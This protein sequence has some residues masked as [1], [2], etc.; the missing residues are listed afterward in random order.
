MTDP[1]ED[2]KLPQLKTEFKVI[3]LD[4]LDDP[5]RPMRSDLSPESVEDLVI[6][7]R[8]VGIIEPLVVKFKGDRYEIIAG[9]RRLLAATIA[10][11]AQVPCYVVEADD[12]LSEILKIHENLFRRE[13]SAIDE[14]KFYDWLIQHYK[15][16]PAKIAGMISKS[17]NYVLDRL[18]ILEYQTELREALAKGQIK[19]SVARAF[20]KVTDLD[21]M[22]KFL[23]YSIRSGIT[24]GLAETWVAEWKRSQLS[25]PPQTAIQPVGDSAG[26]EYITYVD[27]V[28]C[29]EQVKLF[30]ALPVHIH[31]GCYTEI[32]KPN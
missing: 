31:P 21:T 4:M 7:I 29:R 6:S 8:Q 23:Y 20:N 26:E 13:I 5:A 3:S 15:L 25:T 14:S 32:L 12:Q 28:Y 19:F 16:S 2:I 18:Q 27:C 30:D 17:L 1:T 24:P 10:E 11:I 22:R 9:H